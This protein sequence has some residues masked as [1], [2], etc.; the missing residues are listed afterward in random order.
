[1][2]NTITLSEI[3]KHNKTSDCWV[4]MV[5][6]FFVIFNYN[7]ENDRQVIIRKKVYDLTSFLKEHPG[8]AD[9]IL[10]YAGQDATEAFSAVHSPDILA[11]LPSQCILGDAAEM[12]P[13]QTPV[14]LFI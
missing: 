4:R 13:Q 1:M 2:T 11:T 9:V 6:L 12:E 7:Q 10:R 14:C 8:G 3:A 5:P